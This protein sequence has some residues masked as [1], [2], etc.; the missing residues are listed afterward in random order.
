M[1][2]MAEAAPISET[3][4]FDVNDKVVLLLMLLTMS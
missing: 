3:L 4:T 1:W 2:A